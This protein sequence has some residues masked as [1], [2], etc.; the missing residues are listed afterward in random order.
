MDTSHNS[1]AQEP[2][3]PEVCEQGQ[4]ASPST[5]AHSPDS[6]TSPAQP[7][8]SSTKI[9]YEVKHT[10][11]YLVKETSKS[12]V[13]VPLA[14]FTAKIV[15]DLLMDDGI[16]EPIRFYEITAQLKGRPEL[17][18]RIVIPAKDFASMHWVAQLGSDASITVGPYK[19]DHL[20]AAIQFLSTQKTMRRIFGH[21]GWR[22]IR[23]RWVYLHAGGAIGAEG[24]LPQIET[25]LDQLADYELP[26]PPPSQSEGL[27]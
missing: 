5:P 13:Y 23:N 26:A 15:A 4:P 2:Q 11:T 9:T 25:R 12:K 22:N 7:T 14:N 27:R 6:P 1:I 18:P 16:A 19:R 3:D 24:L 8:S 21:T 17:A 20:R 10:K